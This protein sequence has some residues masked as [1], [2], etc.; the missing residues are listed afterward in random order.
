MISNLKLPVLLALLFGI[1]GVVR[2]SDN[3]C[4]VTSDSQPTCVTGGNT[5]SLPTGSA[6]QPGVS[7]NNTVLTNNGTSG[8]NVSISITYQQGQGWLSTSPKT[9]PSFN[10][11]SAGGSVSI[12]ISA[13]TSKLGPGTYNATVKFQ[14]SN[15]QATIVVTLVVEG[16]TLSLSTQSV[17]VGPVAPSPTPNSTKVTINNS[18]DFVVAASTSR[19]DRADI[20]TSMN[21]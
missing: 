6:G 3:L 5:L 7:D 11:A 14:G 4:T 10:V 1:A 18:N 9:P 17:S 15:S 20:G 13:N 2:G 8:T 19:S 21:V 16:I 12:T